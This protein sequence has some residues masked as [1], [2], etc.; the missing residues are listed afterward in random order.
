MV[1]KM[2]FLFEE[3]THLKLSIKQTATTERKTTMYHSNASYFSGSMLFKYFTCY[4]FNVLPITFPVGP[5]WKEENYYA[6]LWRHVQMS[7]DGIMSIPSSSKSLAM[8]SGK[9]DWYRKEGKESKAEVER[10]LGGVGVG[11]VLGGKRG[12]TKTGR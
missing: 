9:W 6:T 12:W 1:R 4:I 5:I 10:W 11:V 2:F 3:Q 7:R 8:P